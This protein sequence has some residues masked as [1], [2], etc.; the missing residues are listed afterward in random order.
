MASIDVVELKSEVSSGL[1]RPMPPTS[2]GRVSRDLSVGSDSLGWLNKE[3]M[4]EEWRGVY[5][6]IHVY[7]R[8]CEC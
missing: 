7:T 8:V 4:K 6:C 3:G 2:T 1:G 5:T